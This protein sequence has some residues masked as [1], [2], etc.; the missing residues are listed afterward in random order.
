MVSLIWCLFR[1]EFPMS[2]LPTGSWNAL[3]PP[4]FKKSW[5]HPCLGYYHL[6]SDWSK[7]MPALSVCNTPTVPSVLLTSCQIFT[8]A[9]AVVWLSSG[10]FRSDV[11]FH[12]ASGFQ[13]LLSVWV[14]YWS[15]WN[16]ELLSASTSPSS[17]CPAHPD[18]GGW[19]NCVKPYNIR[20]RIPSYYHLWTALCSGRAPSKKKKKKNLWQN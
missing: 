17:L 6:D 12:L 15:D 19:W 11:A 13:L 8:D 18:N 16:K 2:P 4:H 9:A 3:V 20:K 10:A 1:I 5:K 7:T 14:I